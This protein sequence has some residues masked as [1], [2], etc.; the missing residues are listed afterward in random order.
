MPRV[1]ITGGTGLIGQKITEL[2]QAQG[3]SVAVLSRRPDFVRKIPAYHWDPDAQTIDASC[4]EDTIAI[5][6]LAGAGVADKRWTDSRKAEILHSRTRST[7]LLHKLLRDHPNEV[8]TVVCAS[9]IGYYGNDGLEMKTEESAPGK[10]FLAQVTVAWENAL[11]AFNDLD[12]RL[13]KI[14]IG[15]VL[16]MEGGALAKLAVPIQWWVGA[17]LG[18]GKQYMSWIHIH[19]LCGIFIYALKNDSLSGSFNGVGPN[20]VTNEELT[21]E[22]ARVLN[23]PLLLPNVPSFVLKGLL[24]EMASMVLGG[25]RVSS[26]KIEDAGYTFLYP[27]VSSALID[28]LH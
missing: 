8:N 28:L 16:T 9:A 21:R 4:L 26:R 14:R 17:P 13:V 25:T 24:G 7:A 1:L 23:K 19:D 12:L 2:L 3:M 6:H 5:I 11:D 18:S 22:V 15:I 20:P 10:D 27:D